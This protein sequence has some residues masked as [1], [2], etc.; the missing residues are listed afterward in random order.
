MSFKPGDRVINTRDEI[1]TVVARLPSTPHEAT[2]VVYDND[3]TI[4]NTPTIK[5]RLVGNDSIERC[6]E[7][8]RNPK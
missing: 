4:W 8:W 2:R 5:L 3:D 7:T 6:I 1:G